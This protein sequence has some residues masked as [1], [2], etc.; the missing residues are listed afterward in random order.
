MFT[1][2]KLCFCDVV[3][4]TVAA[5]K[6]NKYGNKN[7]KFREQETC[8]RNPNCTNI[9]PGKLGRESDVFRS[10]SCLVTVSGRA[11]K[12]SKRFLFGAHTPKI[13]LAVQLLHEIIKNLLVLV[14]SIAF[15]VSLSSNIVGQTVICC[16]V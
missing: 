11:D 15:S 12:R 9:H 3:K 14:I 7:V 16:S 10:C 13:S 1:S 5:Y 8:P 6:S 4:Q 2:K